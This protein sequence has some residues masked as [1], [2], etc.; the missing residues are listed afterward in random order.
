M[1][2]YNIIILNLCKYYGIEFNE[3]DL[4]LRDRE[5]R[6]IFLL[7]IKNFRCLDVNK[8]IDM[9]RYINEKNIKVNLKK[10][11]EKVL[12]NKQFREDYFEIEEKIKKN[13]KNA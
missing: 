4:L 2:K 7:L 8:T 3:L 12:I 9:T 5:K 6:L 13:F 1:D 10:A 11:E